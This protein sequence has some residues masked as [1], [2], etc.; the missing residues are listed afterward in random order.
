[1][2]VAANTAMSAMVAV[3]ARESAYTGKICTWDQMVT[4]ELNTLPEK[5]ELVNVDMTKYETV[6]LAGVTS[7]NIPS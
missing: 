4:S 1:M 7:K 6:P 2:D 5:M 3:M